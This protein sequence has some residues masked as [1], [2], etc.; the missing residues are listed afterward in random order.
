MYS[1]HRKSLGQVASQTMEIS[2]PQR[3]GR[4]ASISLIGADKMEIIDLRE[5]RDI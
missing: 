4:V 3:S 5:N 1:N 2:K